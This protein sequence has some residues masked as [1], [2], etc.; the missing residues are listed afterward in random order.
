[1]K[2]ETPAKEQADK[3]GYAASAHRNAN[4][5]PKNATTEPNANTVNKEPQHLNDINPMISRTSTRVVLNKTS[6]PTPKNN[7]STPS[8]SA[9]VKE[10]IVYN[11]LQF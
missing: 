4:R 8:I 1:M 7:A 5:P 10:A 11:P 9:S 6:T 3:Q 2:S